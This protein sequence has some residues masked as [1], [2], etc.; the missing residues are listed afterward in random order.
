MR[1]AKHELG[2]AIAV[3]LVLMALI[4]IIVVAYLAS[5]RIERS[6]AAVHANRVRAK[7]TADSGLT[8]AIHLLRD[9]T[10][11]GNYITAMPAP[12]PS[13]APLYTEV[14]RPTNLTDPSHAL[15][16]GDYLRL[17]NAAGEILVSRATASLAPGPDSRPT[18]DIVPSPLPSASPFALPS[19]VPALSE[20]RLPPQVSPT[21]VGNSYNFN[22]V[23]RVGLNGSGRLVQPSPTP[24][25]PPALGQWVNVRNSAGDLIGRYAFYVED[26]S[27]KINV[28][29]S[30]NA[31]PAPRPNDLDSPSFP[32]SQV[33]EIDPAGVLPPPPT[34]NRIAADTTLMA[35]G[36]A[37]SRLP[38]KSTV[39]LLDL[40]NW[41]NNFPNYAHMTTV[42]SRNDLTTARGWQR[43]D[44]NTL[45]AGA[46]DN[47][48]K[49]LI[50]N[51]IANWIR[52]AWTGPVTIAT[53]QSFQMFADDRLRLQIAANIVDYIDADSVPTDMGNLSGVPVIGIEKIPYL[54]EVDAV[55]TATGSTPGDRTVGLS[56]RFNFFNMF[57]SDLKL[58]DYVGSMVIKGAPA[59]IKNGT[60]VFD[61][62]ADSF[63]LKVADAAG[64]PD[65]IVPWGG[66]NVNSGVAGVKTFQ[67]PQV[68][69]Q[70]VTYTPGGTISRFES[71]L[72]TVDVLGKNGERL[73]S[74]Q[75][76]LRDLPASNDA[77][78]TTIANDFLEV[79]S[80]A[81]SINSTY[82]AVVSADGSINTIDFGD[83]R[84]RPPV[85]TK[86][87]YNLTRTDTGRFTTTADQAEMDSRV[88]AVDWYD[89][90]GNRPLLFLRNGAMAS[91]GE[92]GNVSVC[93]YPWRTAYLQY[94]G[95]PVNTVD[96]D[97]GP[98]IKD[99]RGSSAAAQTNSAL[100]P[101]DYVLMDLFKTSAQN[102][103]DGSLNIN[104]QFNV[105]NASGSFDQGAF[106]ALFSAIPV[107]SGVP[108]G[109]PNLLTAAAST[110]VSNI[111]ANRR[112]AV[113]PVA[114]GGPGLAG[115]APPVDNNPRRPYFSGGEIASDISWLI[116]QSE[117]A[118]MTG[119]GKTRSS[120]NYSVLRATPTGSTWNRNYGSDMQVEEPFRKI[121]NAITTRGNVFRILYVGQAIK[122]I[123]R[124]GQVDSQSE[125]T[126]EYLGE[127]F[128]ERQSIF[129]PEGSNPDAVKTSDSTYK[130]LTNRVIS[131]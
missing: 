58:S 64:I 48:A 54:V 46:A 10:R 127:V 121:S 81:A 32:V 21:P 114:T 79:S 12:S 53:M 116:N 61:H 19:P 74:I 52:D 5:T 34:A 120:V 97:V 70:Q 99:R 27:M 112:S 115:G 57:E 96:A 59:I 30:G 87:W 122:D 51:R 94:A 91:A 60:V 117:N 83:P 111:A 125:I 9:N 104:T 85:V 24:A 13:P 92:I 128:V 2:F 102:T 29:A 73:D 124:S 86:R 50:A 82:G 18:P 93:E 41:Q 8:A 100:L 11:Y 101:Q 126:A 103:R 118:T 25:P 129:G 26:E 130:I 1:K 72:I 68:A 107:G 47:A 45:V 33:Q 67:T 77:T 105:K 35:A 4:A 15:L 110:A 71:G 108:G 43:L 56:F 42:L 75:I 16:A 31:S 7:I 106:T 28:N 84:Y 95:R 63:T 109:A 40:S 78:S 55:Y 20:E 17:D 38:S 14:Y 22:Q 23:V 37:G 39:A 65:A 76:A 3:T 6:T 62:S 90:V 36:P 69:S 131:E 119:N 49:V 66:D 80:S 89:Y 123:N 44:L 113:A 98:A 88:Y